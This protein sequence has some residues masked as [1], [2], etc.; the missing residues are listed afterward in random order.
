MTLLAPWALW[1]AA[2]GATVVALYLLKIRR[3][4][5][6][7][8]ALDFWLALA[9]RTPVRSLFQ[10]LKRWLSMLLWLVI[11]TCLV[12]ALANPVRTWGRIKPQ[13]IVVILD[14]SASM[15]AVESEH[16]EPERKR[17]AVT[18]NTRWSLALQALADLTRRRPVDDEWLLIEAGATTRVVQPWT[19]AAATI[20]EAA[21][22]LVPHHGRVALAPACRLAAQLLEGRPEPC[23]VVLSDGAAGEVSQLAAQDSRIVP[24]YIGRT[25][26]NL[27]ITRLWVRA[28]REDASHAALV[29]VVNASK[30]NVETRVVF[31]L[32]GRTHSVEPVSIAAGGVWEKTILFN[33]PAGGVLRASLER[34]DALAA[35]NEAYAIL[36]PI[37]PA[38][39]RL[40]ADPGDTFFFEQALLAMEPLV[41]PD[42]SQALTL[43]EYVRQADSLPPADLTIFNN[44]APPNWPTGGACVFINAWPADLP[45]RITGTLPAT[46]LTLVARD[47]PLARYLNL[48]AVALAESREVDVTQRATVLAV[49]STGTP[50]IFAVQQPGRAALCLALDVLA[51]D[52]PLRN[53]FPIL[54]R[55]AVT[56]FAAEQRAWVRPQYGIGETIEPLR[57]VSDNL[58][59]V[60][61]AC[62]RDDRL[63]A[64]PTAP[65]VLETSLPVRDGVFRCGQTADSAVLR[66]TIG[67][68]TA[69]TAVNLADEGESRIRPELAAEDPVQ[70]LALT[71]RWLGT[72]PWVALAAAATVLITLEWLTY[73]FRWTE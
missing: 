51:S 42:S 1:F 24:W 52:L 12:L 48:G 55:N 43:D 72:L 30:E 34:P 5:Q 32:D 29:S 62:F 69:Y 7:V 67:D 63:Q 60:Q 16:S 47:H 11:V 15:Q 40:V 27:G 65:A 54:L 22:Q 13:S 33:A 53:A 4:R 18:T 50:L 10:R 23:I 14:N 58:H 71:G 66:F 36:E 26:D 70:R 41:D 39:V 73:H 44:A 20:R 2:I 3:Q 25:S 31:E 61:V 21:A 46:E 59:A 28:N 56:Y 6:I 8:P 37:R 17:G 68:E 19:R 9:L 57:P 64:G 49:S 35:D 38:S 45:A